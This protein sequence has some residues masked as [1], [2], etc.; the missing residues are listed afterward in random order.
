MIGVVA[1][2]VSERRR[3]GGIEQEGGGPSSLRMF[4]VFLKYAAKTE[5]HDDERT[6][7][8]NCDE[9]SVH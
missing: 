6:H 8:N 5:K 9:H 7:E 3:I 2:V 4:F 1:K